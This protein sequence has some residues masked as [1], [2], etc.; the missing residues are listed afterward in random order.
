[1]R[2]GKTLKDSLKMK[3][4][5][6]KHWTAIDSF[7]EEE[8]KLLN[9]IARSLSCIKNSM[10]WFKTI[11]NIVVSIYSKKSRKKSFKNIKKLL[12]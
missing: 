7:L 2:A 8:I 11:R 1:M 12:I 5:S 6:K 4:N 10:M 9:N 3:F